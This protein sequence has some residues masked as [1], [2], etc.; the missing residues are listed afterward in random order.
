M[1]SQCWQHTAGASARN[2][3]HLVVGAWGIFS[4]CISIMFTSVQIDLKL[5][6]IQQ[7][8]CF[9]LRRSQTAYGKSDPQ[10]GW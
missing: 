3:N 7:I 1:A 10:C 2:S 8:R 4:P 9:A 5:G 6:I